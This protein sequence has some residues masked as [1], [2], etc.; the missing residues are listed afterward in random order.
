M[1]AENTEKDH[2]GHNSG[3]VRRAATTKTSLDDESNQSCNS[4]SK[5]LS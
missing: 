1:K 5:K 2:E 3:G 4:N